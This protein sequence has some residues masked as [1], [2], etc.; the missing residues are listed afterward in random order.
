LGSPEIKGTCNNYRK[1]S[2]KRVISAQVDIAL[3]TVKEKEIKFR[4]I[5]PKS[6]IAGVSTDICAASDLTKRQ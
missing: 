1:L 3:Q 6:S 2:V 4:T 5:R